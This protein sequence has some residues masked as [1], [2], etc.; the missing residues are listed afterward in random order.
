MAITTVLE[1]TKDEPKIKIPKFNDDRYA[2]SG[3]DTTTGASTNSVAI[4]EVPSGS[5]ANITVTT[6]DTATP[7]NERTLNIRQ[8]TSGTVIR[9]LKYDDVL[10]PCLKTGSS[11]FISGD[12][13]YGGLINSGI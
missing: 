7:F 12:G 4:A 9:D 11:C 10:G 5:G 1:G 6:S 8:S 13:I 3:T 2:T